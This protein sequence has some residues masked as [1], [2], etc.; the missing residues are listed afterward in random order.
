LKEE[1]AQPKNSKR[2]YKKKTPEEK[3]AAALKKAEGKAGTTK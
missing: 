2:A 1:E 3:E